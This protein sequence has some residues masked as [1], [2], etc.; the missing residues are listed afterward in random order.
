M[1]TVGHEPRAMINLNFFISEVIFMAEI[2]T[3][4]PIIYLITFPKLVKLKLTRDPSFSLSPS[5]PEDFC[6]SLPAK[7]TKLILDCLVRSLSRKTCR[8]TPQSCYYNS[9]RL[10]TKSI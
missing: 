8:K 10:L 2:N 7:S 1:T 6:L 5:D 3:H 4:A 9:S